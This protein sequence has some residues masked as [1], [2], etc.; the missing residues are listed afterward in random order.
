[1]AGSAMT[2]C[3]GQTAQADAD[4]L[5][6][7]AA[8]LRARATEMERLAKVFKAQSAKQAGQRSGTRQQAKQTGQRS[9]V[10]STRS[11]SPASSAS[12]LTIFESEEENEVDE[13]G[14]HAAM[15]SACNS[16]N[17]EAEEAQLVVLADAPTPGAPIFLAPT[18]ALTKFCAD[19][20]TENKAP[21]FLPPPPGLSLWGLKASEDVPVPVQGAEVSTTCGSSDDA[22]TAE[23]TTLMLRNV[24]N[25]L[26][27]DALCQMLDAEGLSRLYDFLY[28]PAD[29]LR[30]SN[31]G[32]CFVN[33]ASHKAALA[34]WSAMDG[35]K[36]WAVKSQKVCTVQWCSSVQ[37]LDSHIKLYQNSPVM[38][39][40]VPDQFKPILLQAGVRVP[41]PAPTKKIKAPRMKFGKTKRA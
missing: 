11:T 4:Q 16:F 1:M 29:L 28:L 25:E 13:C 10:S 34:A 26:S 33:F 19:M 38:H 14:E 32:Y 36:N 17:A 23:N 2:N 40:A 37:G 7:N 8:E 41:F 31:L 35:F 5:Q 24:P 20:S 6:L 22:L 3:F 15:G 39:E 21:V 18:A 30:H 27:R 9:S 12:L